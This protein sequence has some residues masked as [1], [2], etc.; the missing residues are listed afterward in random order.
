MVAASGPREP[1]ERVVVQLRIRGSAGDHIRAELEYIR[2]VELSLVTVEVG[3]E[4]D[5]SG[6][7]SVCVR[8]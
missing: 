8:E 4:G 1:A 2:N 7:V 5:C 3:N 6:G